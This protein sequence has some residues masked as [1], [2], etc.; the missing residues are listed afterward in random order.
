MSNGE[1]CCILQVCCPPAEAEDA[2]ARELVEHADMSEAEAQKAAKHMIKEYDLAAPGTLKP[3]K[4]SIAK[5]ARAS[6][7][8]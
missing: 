8:D 2:L 7:R 3:L 1:V 5:I 6:T 4:D